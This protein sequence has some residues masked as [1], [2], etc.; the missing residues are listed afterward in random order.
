VDCRPVQDALSVFVVFACLFFFLAACTGIAMSFIR[1]FWAMIII[2]SLSATTFALGLGIIVP[3]SKD[4]ATH[5]ELKP[6]YLTLIWLNFGIIFNSVFTYLVCL[7]Y[8][9]VFIFSPAPHGHFEGGH[10]HDL[11]AAEY[12]AELAKMDNEQQICAMMKEESD[13]K[14]IIEMDES[15]FTVSSIVN[16]SVLPIPSWLNTP[17]ASEQD[18]SKFLPAFSPVDETIPFMDNEEKSLDPDLEFKITRSRERR[19]IR[20]SEL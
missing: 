3:I 10:H 13:S 20:L 4:Y 2:M 15:S 9:I 17:N 1:Q 19:I 18:L 16:P 7:H 12:E 14:M 5:Q 6:H 8:Q 11:E